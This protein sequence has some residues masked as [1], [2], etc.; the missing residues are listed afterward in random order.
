MR[1]F[2]VIVAAVALLAVGG[3]F[4]LQRGPGDETS[5]R[6]AQAIALA[7]DQNPEPDAMAY[8]RDILGSHDGPL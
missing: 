8:A 1:V 7:L 4:L 3:W 2:L 5:D 6:K